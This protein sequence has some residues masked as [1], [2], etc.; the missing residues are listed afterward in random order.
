M[1]QKE[2][3]T[4]Q[5]KIRDII[6]SKG[7]QLTQIVVIVTVI[8][9]ILYDIYLY[10]YTDTIS[11]VIHTNAVWDRYFVLTW[12]WGVMSGHLFLAR[13]KSAKTVPEG[14]AILL[15]I[16]ISVII[17]CLGFFVEIPT[18]GETL[19]LEMHI[20]FLVIGTVCGYFLWPQHYTKENKHDN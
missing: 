9:L 1:S 14:I 13:K 2:H 20:L 3:I 16:L 11:E 6:N 8:G 19:N 18:E 12:I 4:R 15:L 10:A 7:V 5:E 17:Q